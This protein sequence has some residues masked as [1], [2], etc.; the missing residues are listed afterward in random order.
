MVGITAII[1]KKLAPIN[2]SLEATL[3]KY[4][5]VGFP[6]LMPGINPPYFFIFS[7]TSLGSKTT[8]V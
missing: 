4:S 1:A 6:G 2:V 7:A 8:A 5:A 3:S